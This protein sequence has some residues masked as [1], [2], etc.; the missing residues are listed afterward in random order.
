M[1][2]EVALPRAF[3]AKRFNGSSFERFSS[4]W[5]EGERL[6]GC[7]SICGGSVVGYI[8]SLDSEF[9][10]GFVLRCLEVSFCFV[11]VFQVEVEFVVFEQC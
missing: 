1:A 3:G 7:S 11:F 6:G 2:S 5:S 9:D 8:L 4:V 10:A